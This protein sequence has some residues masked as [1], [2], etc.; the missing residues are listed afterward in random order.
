LWGAVLSANKVKKRLLLLRHAS[1][2]AS[3]QHRFLGSTDIGLS[4]LG[5]VE[6]T[7]IAPLIQE[8][9]PERFFCSPLKRC[10]ET[11][12]QIS[13]L[14]IEINPDLREINFG[15]WEGMTFDQI[16]QSDPAAVAQ[17]ANFDAGFSFPGG[18]CISDFL[19]RVCKFA[20]FFASCPEKTIL[21][22]THA[23]VIRTLICHFLGLHSRQY[24]LFNI[25]FA[26]L[27]IIDLFD[28]KGVMT[29]L[30]HRCRLEG[31]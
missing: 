27:T 5:R 9:K 2:A 1:H 16:Q 22:V 3:Y 11:I 12:E 18:E 29:G 25:Q 7:S 24:V 30:N 20:D 26:S 17:W 31:I 15:C 10:T 14:H 28:G 6:A 4:E 8:Y 13:S 19:T 21:A 23:G